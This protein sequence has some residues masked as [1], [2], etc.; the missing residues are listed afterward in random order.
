MVSILGWAV[1]SVFASRAYAQ[2]SQASAAATTV[3]D[4][5][6]SSFGRSSNQKVVVKNNLLYDA[7]LTPNLTVEARTGRRTSVQLTAGFNPFTFSDN[8]KLKHMLFMPEFRLWADSTFYGNYFAVNAFYSHYNVSG[9]NLLLWKDTKTFRYQGDAVAL[10]ASV[11]HRWNFLHRDRQLRRAGFYDSQY[12]NSLTLYDRQSYRRESRWAIEAEVGVDVGYTWYEKFDCKHCGDSYGKDSKPFLTPKL[13]LSV[14]YRLGDI[15]HPVAPVIPQPVDTPLVVSTPPFVPQV[16][17][18]KEFGGVADS[19][20]TTNPVLVPMDQYRPYDATLILRKEKGALYVHFP[21]NTTTLSR[22]FRDNASK[23]DQ[24]IGVTQLIMADTT[25]AVQRIQIVGLA[26][27]EGNYP[28]NR[29]LAD[30]RAK[31]LQAY[32]Q[33][34][35]DVPDS[36][37]ET[38]GGA[39][40]WAEFRDQINDV[41]I[42]KTGGTVQMPESGTYSQPNTEGITIDEIDQLF[43]IID[44]DAQPDEKE[45]RIRQMNNGRTYAYLK[46]NILSDQRNSGYIRIYWDHVP[47]V[48]AQTINRASALL[49]QGNAQE[50]LQLLRTVSDDPR[51]FNILGV[52]LYQTGNRQQAI[53]YFRRAAANGDT[54][55]QENLRQAEY[56]ERLS[57]N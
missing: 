44:S 37:F 51:S 13:G 30:G 27:I 20:M 9:I 4:S 53:D 48:K 57:K 36:L 8:K 10:G 56:R 31:A 1:S 35:V 47:D 40:A 5:L 39:E 19:L 6:V 23:L 21:V 38:V 32:V 15:D 52:A 25:S 14:I 12:Y 34:H 2:E 22:D 3:P 50:A 45:R 43:Q 41:R 18:V 46:E 29:D 28:H 42:L 55:A 54:Q 7:T 16:A 17:A 49:R 33:Q 11:G 26:S 24:I